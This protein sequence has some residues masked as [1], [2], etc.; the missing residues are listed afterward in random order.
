MNFKEYFKKN[1]TSISPEQE[2]AIKAIGILTDLRLEY[3]IPYKKIQSI[4]EII[5]TFALKESL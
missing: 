4:E 3:K 1:P 5:Y 2:R